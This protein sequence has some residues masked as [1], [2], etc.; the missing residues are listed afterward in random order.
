MATDE[1][2]MAIEASRKASSSASILFIY[3]VYL[4]YIN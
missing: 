1:C 2:V 3:F 4:L